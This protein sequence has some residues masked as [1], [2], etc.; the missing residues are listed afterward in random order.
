MIIFY[1]NII[2]D[3]LNDEESFKDYQNDENIQTQSLLPLPSSIHPNELEFPNSYQIKINNTSLID[4]V[5]ES[6]ICYDKSIQ[7]VLNSSFHMSSYSNNND[8]E[9]EKVDKC[10]VPPELQFREKM[11]EEDIL[12][13]SLVIKNNHHV[14]EYDIHKPSTSKGL[15]DLIHQP[16]SSKDSSHAT[17]T[18]NDTKNSFFVTKQAV[19]NNSFDINIPC[20]N[21]LFDNNTPSTSKY[22]FYENCMPSTSKQFYKPKSDVNSILLHKKTI[23]D[24]SNSIPLEQ[25]YQEDVLKMARKFD[26]NEVDAFLGLYTMSQ[27]SDK[28]MVFMANTTEQNIE[29]DTNLHLK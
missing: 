8:N 25:Y 27:S 24:S 18:S 3:E 12:N 28:P 10:M 2:K 1:R 20:E 26:D 11:V 17:N 23:L 7:N 15:F 9:V 5:N 13:N 14:A 29:E 4:T 16:G 21:N 22:S 19:N 6:N